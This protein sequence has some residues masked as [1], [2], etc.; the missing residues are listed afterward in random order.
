[1][2]QQRTCAKF[3]FRFALLK[4]K[5][6]KSGLTRSHINFS[7]LVVVPNARNQCKNSLKFHTLAKSDVNDANSANVY[8]PGMTRKRK[9]FAFFFSVVCSVHQGAGKENKTKLARAA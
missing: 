5:A 3:Q 2:F 1:M 9:M 4:V 7:Y 8:T 6:E